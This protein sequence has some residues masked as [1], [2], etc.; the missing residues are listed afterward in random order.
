MLY[1]VFAR[2]NEK[3]EKT[4]ESI[5]NLYSIFYISYLRIYMINLRFS[6]YEYLQGHC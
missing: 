5:Y 4:F 2:Y 6:F 3:D 1:V